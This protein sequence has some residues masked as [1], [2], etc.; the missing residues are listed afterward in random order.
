MGH[1]SSHLAQT[2]S[3]ASQNLLHFPALCQLIHQL[4]QVS[5]PLRQGI[6]DLLH[7]TPADCPADE[8]CIRVQ[9]G[10]LE[11]Y[12]KSRIFL[13]QFLKLLVIESC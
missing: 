10:A 9:R 11:E 7:P 3:G 2:T 8:V 4:I 12:F 5:N 1:R 13:Y 6:L